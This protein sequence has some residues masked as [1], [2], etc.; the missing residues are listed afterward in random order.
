[1]RYIAVQILLSFPS[2]PS[3]NV[4]GSIS[5]HLILLMIISSREEENSSV[6]MG[7]D[8]EALRE[9]EGEGKRR[10]ESGEQRRKVVS[11]AAIETQMS[12]SRSVK[13]Y[14]QSECLR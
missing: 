10:V 11:W 13:T 12:Y 3:H 9:G 6:A 7:A 4:E 1:M 2:N 8:F 14:F 5:T